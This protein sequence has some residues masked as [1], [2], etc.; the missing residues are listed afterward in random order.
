MEGSVETKPDLPEQ[1]E[2]IPKAEPEEKA[3]EPEPPKVEKI[4]SVKEI[5]P[6]D[7]KPAGQQKRKSF[8]VNEFNS[9]GGP[10]VFNTS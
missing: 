8:D 10:G 2:Q 5:S 4:Q 3:D 1:P 7:T 6:K 9:T